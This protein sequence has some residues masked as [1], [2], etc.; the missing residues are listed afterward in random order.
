MKYTVTMQ[1]L[2]ST[3]SYLSNR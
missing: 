1:S 3:T 2:H